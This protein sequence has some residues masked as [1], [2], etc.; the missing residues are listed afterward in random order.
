MS[1]VAVRHGTLR[2]KQCEDH[3]SK[4]RP[5]A[6]A[7][8]RAALGSM[9]LALPTEIGSDECVRTKASARHTAGAVP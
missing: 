4:A 6:H 5:A 1:R 2:Q 8:Q 3:N 7:R 9:L